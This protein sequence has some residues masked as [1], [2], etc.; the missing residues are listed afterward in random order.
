VCAA[1]AVQGGAA[2]AADPLPFVPGS[3]TIAVL[4]DT[5]R[6][7]SS[8]NPAVSGILTEMTTWLAA[9]KSARDIQFV[10]TE[11]DLTDYNSAAE[12]GRVKASFSVL[13]GQLPYAMVTGNH[14]YG[15]GGN[16]GDRTT[17]LNSYFGITDNPL[18]DP[19]HG[20]AAGGFYQTGRLENTYYRFTAPDGRK[21][22]IFALE[23]GPRD[24]VVS[25]AEGVAAAHSDHTAALVTHAYLYS[26]DTRYNW[27]T[28]GSS[29]SWNPHAYSTA[30]EP[31]GTN[32]GE[33]L[34]EKLVSRNGNFELTFNGHVL[35]GG[36]G[37][38]RSTAREGN[39]VH[40]MLFN[41]QFEPNG[42][43]GWLR[44]IEFL[45]DGQTVRAKTYSPH[46]DQWRTDPANQFTFQIS[47]VPEPATLA[48]LA[49][50]G[51]AVMW[52]RRR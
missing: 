11:G 31:G 6:Y 43:N 14:D 1:L 19:A 33:E 37:Y 21:M 16:A 30:Y 13:D 10:L 17:S 18:N 48:I 42:G 52:R 25:W 39:G 34:W 20:G 47:L 4:P 41:A 23:W 24:A 8:S 45:P 28:R 46:L 35:N 40:Q 12:W 22:L 32:D 3:W 29:Q 36:R 51:L 2:R 38:L 9:Q 15:P 49:L 27:A 5:Q 26:D 7:A 50:G 44:L